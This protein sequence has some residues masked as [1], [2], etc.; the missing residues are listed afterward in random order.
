MLLNPI[1]CLLHNTATDRWHPILFV[2][3]P[4]PG[5]SKII[6]HKSKGHH[7]Q[8]FDSQEA[9]NQGAKELAANVHARLLLEDVGEWDGTA[10]PAAIR[11]FGPGVDAGA[12]S[13]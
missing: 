2:E 11:F 8:G 10:L 1:V 9:A 4:P 6:R 12:A 13:T 3:S 7:T 5:D